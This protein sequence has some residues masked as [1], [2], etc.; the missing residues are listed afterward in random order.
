MAIGLLNGVLGQKQNR[1]HGSVPLLALMLSRCEPRLYYAAE[2]LEPTGKEAFAALDPC[3]TEH[4]FLSG[5]SS[6]QLVFPPFGACTKRL[7]ATA[8]I[9]DFKSQALPTLQ[10][11]GDRRASRLRCDF[12]TP[13]YPC[14]CAHPLY[15]GESGH[16]I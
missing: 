8:P 5:L 15:C 2:F 9:R 11:I 6:S 4:D 12:S 7:E 16:H 10:C 1:I 14:L 13:Q 3:I